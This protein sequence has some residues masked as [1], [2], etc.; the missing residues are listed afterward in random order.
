LGFLLAAGML[1]T[2]ACAPSLQKVGRQQGCDIAEEYLPSYIVH[3]IKKERFK[4]NLPY[5]MV[6]LPISVTVGFLF[7]YLSQATVILP[8]IAPSGHKLLG[9]E[10]KALGLQQAISY[11]PLKG[12]KA[13]HFDDSV[14][15]H[16]DFDVGYCY[17]QS[18]NYSKAS[19]YFETLLGSS[20][21]QYIGEQ[22]LLFILGDCYYMLSLYDKS[23][24]AYRKFLDYCSQED[25]RIQL[26]NNRI[27]TIDALKKK[28][29]WGI[30]HEQ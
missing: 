28:G 30:E 1:I 17:Y 13:D 18:G 21:A 2:A 5:R 15:A 19:S 6:L 22:N 24:D 10:F 27:K 7:N 4:K 9:N 26:V 11:T 12:S 3:D 29:L 16:A 23:V 8:L 20:Y 25:D 14:I